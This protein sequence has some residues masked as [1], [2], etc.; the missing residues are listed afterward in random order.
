MTAMR[1]SE[2]SGKASEDTSARGD[3]ARPDDRRSGYSSDN[4]EA[5][6]PVV[7]QSDKRIVIVVQ[8]GHIVVAQNEER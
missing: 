6:T 2:R 1:Y 7:V 3:R 4:P 8:H 5:T